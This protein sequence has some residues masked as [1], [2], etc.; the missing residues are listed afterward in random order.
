MMAT[1]IVQRKESFTGKLIIIINKCGVSILTNLNFSN[2]VFNCFGI[3]SLFDTVA[4]LL[5]FYLILSN[6]SGNLKIVEF[7]VKRAS[8]AHLFVSIKLDVCSAGFWQFFYHCCG[9]TTVAIKS[10]HHPV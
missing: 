6:V 8:Y 1:Y 2:K 7:S 9:K 5:S 4:K 10:I 3:H